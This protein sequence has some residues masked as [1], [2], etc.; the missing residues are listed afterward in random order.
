MEELNAV[1][2]AW[3]GSVIQALATIFAALIAAVGLGLGI[4]ASW[5]TSLEL[6]RKDKI[7]ETRREIYTDFIES[8]TEMLN[9][10]YGAISSPDEL[11]DRISYCREATTNFNKSLDKILFVCETKNKR[12]LVVF[13][14]LFLPK[15]TYFMEDLTN[16]FNQLFKRKELEEDYVETFNKYRVLMNKLEQEENLQEAQKHKLDSDIGHLLNIILEKETNLQIFNFE[17]KNLVKELRNEFNILN[18]SSQENFLN[19]MHL[20]RQEIGIESDVQLE[21]ELNKTLIKISKDIRKAWE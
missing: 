20:L 3:K 8:Y 5:K 13:I 16:Y 1:E 19:V 15:L 12:E 9:I 7:Y 2:M 4:Y 11:K 21:E 10:L 17:I 6:Q 14:G 18:E